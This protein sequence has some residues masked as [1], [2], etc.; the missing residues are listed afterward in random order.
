[1]RK[2]KGSSRIGIILIALAMVMFLVNP[3][4]A[5]RDRQQAAD[6]HM[7]KIMPDM[8][9]DKLKGF[10][11]NPQ[12]LNAKQNN[13]V[14]WMNGVFDKEVQVVFQEGKTCRDV[15]ANPNLKM[16]G[17]FLDSK[18]CYVTSFLPY[19]M[20]STLQFINVGT[21]DYEVISEDGTMTAKGKII[22]RP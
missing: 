10:Y 15:T 13:I 14:V 21:Y 4:I 9:E 11:L 7:V 3:A 2:L 22:V 6:A 20:T 16:P 19:S 18:S 5:Q 17:F 8:K 1:M 12:V